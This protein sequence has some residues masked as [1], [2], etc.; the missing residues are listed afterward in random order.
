MGCHGVNLRIPFVRFFFAT[1]PIYEFE[2]LLS[3]IME[4]T[5][6]I[7]LWPDLLLPHPNQPRSDQKQGK[8]I[9]KSDFTSLKTYQIQGTTYDCILTIIWSFSLTEVVVPTKR[10]DILNCKPKTNALEQHAQIRIHDLSRMVI[11]VDLY[12][13]I[14]VLLV[15]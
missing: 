11:S 7:L 9:N 8:A 5:T 3:Y 6:C 12:H 10:R 14:Y 13:D 1:W 15:S 4:R 2:K